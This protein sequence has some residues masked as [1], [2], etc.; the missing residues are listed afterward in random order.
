MKTST[1]PWRARTRHGA[2]P[3]TVKRSA[4]LLLGAISLAALHGTTL[5][6]PPANAAVAGQSQG[7]AVRPDASTGCFIP[8]AGAEGSSELRSIS[9]GGLQRSYQLHLPDHFDSKKAWPIVL[10]FHGRGNTG[11]GT[12]AFSGLDN[13]PAIVAYPNGVIGQGDGNRQAWQGAPYAA[14]GVDDVAFTGDLLDE[15]ERTLCVD[16]SRVYATGKSNGG[17]FTGILACNLSSRITAIAPVA[18]AFYDTGRPCV[19]ERTVPVIEFH[20]TGDSTIPYS[21]DLDRGLPAITD[22]AADWAARNGCKPEAHTRAIA[23]DASLSRWNGC[24]P[25][26]EV[27]HVFVEDGGHTWPGADSYSG[28][29][30]TTQNIEAHEIMWSFLHTKRLP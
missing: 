30:Y 25:G 13:L 15:L 19:P 5:D 3:H 7:P 29:G 6:A 23:E 22:W 28:G 24:A 2:S 4:L 8:T 20:G 27:E 16:T 18:A 12:E 21:G 10:A 26:G 9:S 14:P 1:T 17:G 11:A